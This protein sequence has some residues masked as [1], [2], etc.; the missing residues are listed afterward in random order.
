M[1][2]SYSLRLLFIAVA[3]ATLSACIADAS[4]PPVEAVAASRSAIEA[5]DPQEATRMLKVAARGGDLHAMAGLAVAYQQGYYAYGPAFAG[6]PGR[7]HLATHQSD[8]QAQRWMNRYVQTVRRPSSDP[9]HRHLL[10]LDLL[11]GQRPPESAWELRSVRQ[12]TPRAT[13]AQRDSA[14][15]ILEDLLAS[16][17]PGVGLALAATTSDRSRQLEIYQTAAAHGD[18][19]ACFMA[20][21]RSHGNLSIAAELADYLSHRARCE[22]LPGGERVDHTGPL[23]ALRAQ[24]EIGNPASIALMDSLVVLGAIPDA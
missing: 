19:Q 14:V 12:N 15:A 8:L 13:P 23:N 20:A 18:V 9:T 11:N 17:Q 3:L 1:L 2:I 21:Y 24:A 4:L 16:G 22:A 5:G 10:A 6:P 7:R